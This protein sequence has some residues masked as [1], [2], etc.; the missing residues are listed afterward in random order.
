M[1]RSNRAW[2]CGVRV[3][4]AAATV[5]FALEASADTASDAH[6]EHVHAAA[7]AVAALRTT[8]NYFVPPIT[9]VRDD[10]KSVELA[11]ELNDGRAVVLNF[12]YTTC[13]GICPLA[14]QVFSQLQRKLGPDRDRVHLVSISIDPE[15]D[16]PA[17]LREYAQRYHAGPSWQHYTGTVAASVTAQRAFNVYL[18]DKMGHTPV[19]L[20]RTAPGATWVRFDGFATPDVL[21]QELRD[22]GP[23]AASVSSP[24]H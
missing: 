2:A 17:R 9:L 21:L 6:A 13:S 8:V 11:D 23:L 4:A 18:G 14:S 10:G 1:S 5:S 24:G 16:T 3:I 15:E 20:V 7:P 19:T 12:I 22:H